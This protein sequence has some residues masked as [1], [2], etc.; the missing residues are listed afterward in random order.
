MTSGNVPVF[1]AY[2]FNTGYMSAYGGFRRFSPFFYVM[3]DLG[4]RSRCLVLFTLVFSAMLGS[5][6]DLGDD[7]VELLVFSTLLGSTGAP[8]DDFVEM[9]VFSAMLGSTFDTWCCQSSWPLHRCSSWTRL[10]CLDPEVHHNGG[11]A[12]AVHLQ[13]RQHPCRCAETASHGLTSET[14]EILLLQY[15][16]NVVDVGCASPASSLLRCW[17]LSFTC[18]LLCNDRCLGWSRQCR[19]CGSSA[20]GI[21]SWTG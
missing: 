1:S 9:V 2:W 18:L 16:D 3:V 10:F 8:R 7:F 20:V 6:F 14:I 15:I 5:T 12:V 11:A 4:S 19:I 13:G 17:T 21:V